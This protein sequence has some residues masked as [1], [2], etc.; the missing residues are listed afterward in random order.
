MLPAVPEEAPDWAQALD[1]VANSIATHERHQRKHVA[2]YQERLSVL[3]TKFAASVIYGD[4]NS[5]LGRSM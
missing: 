2:T 4:D 1:R 5:R 3:E